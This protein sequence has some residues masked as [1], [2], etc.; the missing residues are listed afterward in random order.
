MKRFAKSSAVGVLAT[1]V[2]YGMLVAGVELMGLPKSWVNACSLVMGSLVQFLGNRA[3][4]FDAAHGKLSRQAP[5]YILV[6][7]G[8][9]GLNILVFEAL[10]RSGLLHYAVARI[11]GT[12]L[13]F[14]CYNFPMWRLVFRTSPA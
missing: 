4:V 8:G 7:A 12:F 5:A 13:V 1:G 2:S 3:W 10:T 6:E 14:A 11:V 9:I